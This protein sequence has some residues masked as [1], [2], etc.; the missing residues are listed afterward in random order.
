ME[1]SVDFIS[2]H[3]ARRALAALL[4]HS[5]QVPEDHAF[6]GD[7][8]IWDDCIVPSSE[9]IVR[10]GAYIAGSKELAACAGV[11]MA[12][13]STPSGALPVALIGAVA[14]HESYRGAGL[15]SGL[16]SLATEWAQ[17]RGACAVF[18]WGSEYSLYN[19]L[20]FELCGAQVMIPLDSLSFAE[21][22]AL[23]VQTGWDHSIFQRMKAREGGLALADSDERW[24]ASHRSVEW[25]WLGEGQNCNAYAAVGRGID[26][27]NIVH[28]WG[29]EPSALRSLLGWLKRER[30]GLTILGAPWILERFGIDSQNAQPEFLCLAQV[31]QPERLVKAYYPTADFSAQPKEGGFYVKSQQEKMELSA[32]QTARLIFG[33]HLEDSGRQLTVPIPLWIWGLDAV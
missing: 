26:L 12:R 28:E 3:Q 24:M 25:F 14:T 16:V 33:P 10:L 32:P 13:L 15:A 23:S 27:E 31:L 1:F 9:E 21:T 11:R 30:P 18:L 7:F 6:L 8:P 19:R 5:F 20:G 22:A 29:G 2:G 4:N 17:T